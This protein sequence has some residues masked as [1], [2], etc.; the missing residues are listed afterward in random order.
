[1]HL[2][3][4]FYLPVMPFIITVISFAVLFLVI[5]FFIQFRLPKATLQELLKA[6]EMG[7]G[8]IK[9]SKVKSFLAVLLLIVG[10][11]IALVA[12]GQLV[13]MVMFPVIFLVILGTKFLFDQLSVSVIERLKRKPKIFWKKPIWSFYQI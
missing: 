1:M 3:L 2:G 13:L 10:Y 5:S 7:K 6:G 12:K 11:G 9:S 4:G 8:E